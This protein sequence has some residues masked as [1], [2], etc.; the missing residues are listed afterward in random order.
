MRISDWSSDVCSSDLPSGDLRI[1]SEQLEESEALDAIVILEPH[2]HRVHQVEDVIEDVRRDNLE[3]DV[4]KGSLRCGALYRMVCPPTR[5]VS[6]SLRTGRWRKAQCFGDPP[7]AG[8]SR[9][10]RW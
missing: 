6:R 9:G 7:E 10:R 2:S 4:S 3:S 5:R 8:S 1:A